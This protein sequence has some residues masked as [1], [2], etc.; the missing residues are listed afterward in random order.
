M[1][2]PLGAS[3]LSSARGN[4]ELEWLLVHALVYP[5]HKVRLFSSNVV[6]LTRMGRISAKAFSVL[7]NIFSL[8]SF[9]HLYLAHGAS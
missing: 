4:D 3:F 7:I 9:I 8:N 1:L 5:G 2:F 6:Y